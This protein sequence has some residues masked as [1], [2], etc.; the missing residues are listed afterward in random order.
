MDSP[1]E[2]EPVDEETGLVSHLVELR[3]RILYALAGV[4]FV[5]LLLIPF[6]RPLFTWA[7]QPLLAV[8]PEG[9]QMVAVDVAAPFLTPFKF[10][11]FVAL[12]LA[13]PWVLY[14]AW[15]FVAPGLYREER[16]LALPLL[17]SSV[18]LFYL[19]CAFAYALVFPLVFG[20]F[21]ASAP[22]G[23][24]VMTDISRY[25]DFIIVMLLAFGLAFEVPVAV[26]IIVKLGWLSPEDLARAR[27]YV[28]VGAFVLAML[29]TPPDVFSQILLAVPICVLYELGLQ[30][31]R[32]LARESQAESV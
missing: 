18:T 27:P 13:M 31:S 3:Q 29:V 28:I 24:L 7:A 11:A 26:L 6:V 12:V 1:R 5:F 8:L 30:V 10:A 23:V 14:Q 25:L 4:L 2:P 9:A 22:E 17:V 19:G 16:R 20:F 32:L 15:A 21:A